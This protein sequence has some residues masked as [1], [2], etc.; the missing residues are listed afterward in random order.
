VKLACSQLNTTGSWWSWTTFRPGRQAKQPV[1]GGPHRVEIRSRDRIRMTQ[2]TNLI[3][4]TTFFAALII[5]TNI[6]F[7]DISNH[8]RVQITRAGHR[9]L[10]DSHEHQILLTTLSL[11]LFGSNLNFVD[12]PNHLRIQIPVD[13]SNQ[14]TELTHWQT[15]YSVSYM[16]WKPQQ[17]R[18]APRSNSLKTYIKNG[19]CFECMRPMIIKG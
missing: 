12:I 5:Y 4:L 8:F 6:N 7:V 1:H 3:L 9:R 2:T 19:N 10:E 15:T 11:I 13:K 17:N 14:I 18:S 16:K